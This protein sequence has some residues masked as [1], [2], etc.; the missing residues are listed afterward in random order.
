MSEK[1]GLESKM[2]ECMEKYFGFKEFKSELQKNAIK[3]AV[4]SKLRQRKKKK[5]T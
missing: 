4:T 5:K 3:C 1:E 2:Y